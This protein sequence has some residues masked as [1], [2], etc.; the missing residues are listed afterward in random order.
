MAGFLIA[1]PGPGEDRRALWER[2]R[3]HRRLTGPVPGPWGTHLLMLGIR[4]FHPRTRRI[5]T[6]AMTLAAYFDGHPLVS[7]AA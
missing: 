5:P 1:A 6:T 2:L 4:T 3:L 7:R